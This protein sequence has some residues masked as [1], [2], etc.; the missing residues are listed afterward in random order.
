MEA[1]QKNYKIPE[2]MIIVV[3][4]IEMVLSNVITSNKQKSKLSK[5]KTIKATKDKLSK[6]KDEKTEEEIEDV[7]AYELKKPPSI[8]LKDYLKRIVYY[9][10]ISAG[11]LISSLILMDR[12]LNMTDGFLTEKNVHML[13]HTAVGVSMK[14]TED[15]ILNAED[16]AYVGVVSKS[17]LVKNERIFLNAVDFKTH[18]NMKDF[19]RYYEL[20]K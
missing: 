4:R 11:T 2:N 20:F 15:V 3:D 19:R 16:F 13:I 14:M 8:K 17:R 18:V 12:V 7:S 6:T 1:T 5:E 10:K 9:S